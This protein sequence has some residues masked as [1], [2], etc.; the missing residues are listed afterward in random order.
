MIDD[1]IMYATF[2]SIFQYQNWLKMLHKIYRKAHPYLVSQ[3]YCTHVCPKMLT[4][5]LQRCISA[6]F[7]FSLKYKQGNF[8]FLILM[9]TIV[10]LCSSMQDN[11]MFNLE[12]MWHSCV[13]TINVKLTLESLGKPYKQEFVARKVSFPLGQHSLPWIMIYKG[14]LTPFVC[15]NIDLPDDRVIL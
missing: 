5:K 1:M 10:V 14:S 8:V 3:V 15:F 13:M 2:L 12:T 9:K 7:N 6:T 11:I 4:L